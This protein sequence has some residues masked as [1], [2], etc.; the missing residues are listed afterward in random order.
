M[1]PDEAAF[2]AHIAEWLAAH[3]GYTGWKLGTQPDDFDA[4]R[5]VDT[6]EL[7]AFIEETRRPLRCPRGTRRGAGRFRAGSCLWSG[8]RR[9]QRSLVVPDT[10]AFSICDPQ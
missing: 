1:K 9:S 7:F 4:G 8:V 10:P 3:G 6:A 5:A 2:E